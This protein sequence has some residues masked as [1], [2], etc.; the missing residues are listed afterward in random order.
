MNNIDINNIKA[1]NIL[2]S[3]EAK[4]ITKKEYI[5]LKEIS[6]TIKKYIED[7]FRE[8]ITI[9]GFIRYYIEQAIRKSQYKNLSSLEKEIIIANIILPDDYKIADILSANGITIDHLKIAIR[10]RSLLK[11][12]IL[13]KVKI[14]PELERQFTI[15]K[16]FVK[17]ITEIFQSKFGINDQ[18]IIFNRICEIMTL[19]PEYFET[20]KTNLLRKK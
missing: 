4:T 20:K 7:N 5:K 3:I 6:R 13:N 17:I 14:N 11:Q 15:Y 2:T 1:Q 12:V 19:H 16:K 18:N 9:S 8:N 10:F